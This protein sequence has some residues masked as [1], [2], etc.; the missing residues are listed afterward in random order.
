MPEL[1]RIKTKDF[2]FSVKAR[3][4]HNKRKVLKNTLA[5]RGKN[6]A[7]AAVRFSPAL[8]LTETPRFFADATASLLTLK[9]NEKAIDQLKLPYSTF[10]EN[11]QYQIEWI[12]LKPVESADIK[13]R[14]NSVCDAFFF[15]PEEDGVNARLSGAINT[16]NDVGW[17]RL[18]YV[19]RLS[20]KLIEGNISLEVLPTKMDMQNDLQAMYSAIDESF[21]LWRFSLAEKTEQGFSLSRQRGEFPLLWLANFSALRNRLNQGLKVITQA[22]HNRLQEYKVSVAADRLK[23]KQPPRL[24]HQIKEDIAGGEFNKKYTVSR[25]SLSIDTP[26]NRFIKMVVQQC[27]K[28]LA[29]FENRLRLRN[30]SPENQY[31]SDAFLD[32]LN[33]W[34][35][36]LNRVLSNSFLKDVGAF[37]GMNSESLVLQQKTGYS[38]VYRAWQELK[39]YLDAFSGM[40][41]VSVKSVAEIYEVWCFLQVKNILENELGFILKKR[42]KAKIKQDNFSGHQLINGDKGAFELTREA[43]GVTAKLYHERSF[44][45]S[46]GEIRTFL[47][48]HRPDILL[49]IN[50][51]DGRQAI[52][53]FDAKYRI[54]PIKTDSENCFSG[55]PG[56]SGSENPVERLEDGVPDEALN[57]MHRYRDALI[58]IEGDRDLS[59]RKKSRPVFGAF[60]LYP[61]NF[62]QLS[63]KN[64]YGD[65]IREIGIG[66]FALLPDGSGNSGNRWLTDFLREQTA[67]SSSGNTAYPKGSLQDYLYVQE[68]ARIPYYGMK[69]VLY[70][71]L[72]MAVSLGEPAGREDQYFKRFINGTA[73]FYHI[74]EATFRLKFKT[75]VV[76]EIRFLAL[77]WNHD[78]LNA[79]K[80]ISKIWPVH[81]IQRKVRKNISIEQSGKDSS[82]EAVYILFELGKALTLGRPVLG[83]PVDSFR[84]SMKLTTLN[85]LERASD[86]DDV[87][88]VYSEALT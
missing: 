57:Q 43:D 39:Y 42:H 7:T 79:T 24:I 74:P 67:Y 52:W 2:L 13:H 49:E 65:A 32:E 48:T 82:S 34:Q 8:Q 30:E 45:G 38:T 69:Q 33:S 47:L 35:K 10:F 5:G 41:N 15:S 17:M 51:P 68:T 50:F 75:H 87:E 61:G 84:K 4:L 71:D 3:S 56:K 20:G 28:R 40:N 66:A 64:P 70:P 83:V 63:V 44:S 58:R 36:P 37:R 23:R 26:E 60:A 53:L 16:G 72:T 6:D 85:M 12:F 59:D 62:N 22:P 1:L 55:K 21:P 46:M 78:E 19:Y 25:K 86:F 29:A 54:E 77:S 9:D 14:L 80:A 76:N 11:T 18:P 81:R 73:G 88:T 31:F 27:R